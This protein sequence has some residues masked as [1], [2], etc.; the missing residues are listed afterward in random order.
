MSNIRYE[1]AQLHSQQLDQVSITTNTENLIAIETDLR[2][3]QTN[4]PNN[5]KTEAAASKRT[6]A[7][8]AEKPT[9]ITHARD[10]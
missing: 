2:N 1:K 7:V 4:K 8:I 3:S 5:A 6:I 10:A 9:K